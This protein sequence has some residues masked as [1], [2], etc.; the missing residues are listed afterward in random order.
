M[1]QGVSP[2]V[3]TRV[4]VLPPERILHTD[5]VLHGHGF[6]GEL[7]M[8]SFTFENPVAEDLRMLSHFGITLGLQDHVYDIHQGWPQRLA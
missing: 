4:P 6:A 2:L 3:K 7:G 8:L 5:G 1:S